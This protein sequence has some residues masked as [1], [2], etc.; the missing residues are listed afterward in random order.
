[1]ESIYDYE[2]R[3]KLSDN[4]IECLAYGQGSRCDTTIAKTYYYDN[5]NENKK[6]GFE[7]ALSSD[8][9]LSAFTEDQNEEINRDL[10]FDIR[11]DDPLYKPLDKALMHDNSIVLVEENKKSSKSIEV[12]RHEGLIKIKFTN[13]L[14][15]LSY[16]QNKWKL[17]IKIYNLTYNLSDKGKY[18]LLQFFED[19]RNVYFDMDKKEMEEQKQEK[20]QKEYAKILSYPSM[21]VSGVM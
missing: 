4:S 6:N 20:E 9:Q 11:K 21:Q 19:A 8:L 14:G 10:V 3:I 18:R 7:L 15:R 1:M 2:R 13:N 12:F 5:K 16:D 17:E